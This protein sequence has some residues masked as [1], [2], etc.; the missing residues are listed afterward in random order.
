[1]KRVG[2]ESVVTNPKPAEEYYVLVTRYFPMA[3]RRRRMTLAA[4]PLNAWDRTLAPTKYLLQDVKHNGLTWEDYVR[5]FKVE[6]PYREAV[7]ELEAHDTN[8]KAL[9][10]ELV[11]VCEEPDSAYPKCHTWIL[12]E[13]WQTHLK[14][15]A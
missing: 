12:L 3:L 14:G 9:G 7:A 6:R 1:V 13:Y 5:R 8:A 15:E 4:S 11:L 10:K 2:I